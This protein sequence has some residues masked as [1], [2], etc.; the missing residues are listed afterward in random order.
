MS[1]ARKAK[2]ADKINCPCPL[3]KSTSKLLKGNSKKTF[4][5]EHCCIEFKTDSKYKVINVFNL[6]ENGDVEEVKDWDTK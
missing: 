3:C 1:T 6:T 4:F 2:K 5:C